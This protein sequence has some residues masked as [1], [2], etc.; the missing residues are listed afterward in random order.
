MSFPQVQSNSY[1]SLKHTTSLINTQSAGSLRCQ[2]T[3]AQN[4]CK[5]QRGEIKAN[6]HIL[7]NVKRRKGSAAPDKCGRQ[8]A[9][10]V[11]DT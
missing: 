5:E 3:P 9:Q 6:A 1:T 4:L 11:T 2:A 10:G 7:Y 8:P